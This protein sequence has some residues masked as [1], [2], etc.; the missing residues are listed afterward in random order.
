MAKTGVVPDCIRVQG[1]TGGI[2]AL[3]LS[4]GGGLDGGEGG[5]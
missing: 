5:G 3:L 2:L 1:K 4:F